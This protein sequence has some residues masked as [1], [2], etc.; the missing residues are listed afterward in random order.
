MSVVQ[1][2]IVNFSHNKV[3]GKKGGTAFVKD[4]G[5]TSVMSIIAQ[6]AQSQ[7]GDDSDLRWRIIPCPHDPMSVYIVSGRDK[8][9]SILDTHGSAVTLW[10]GGGDGRRSLETVIANNTSKYAGNIRWRIIPCP[11]KS[12]Y[13]SQ[14]YIINVAHGKFL[15][16]HGGAVQV[17]NNAGRSVETII[18]QNTSKFA[19][20]LRW[21]LV[22]V[23]DQQRYLVELRS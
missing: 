16:T 13:L 7:A 2:Y 14:V 23:R 6:D 17:W 4:N 1:C 5:A 21:K 18:Q 15:D 20:N 19:P 3:L 12:A 10:N 22:T 11:Y 8:A 9:L